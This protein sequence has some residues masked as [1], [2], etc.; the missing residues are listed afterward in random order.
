MPF[1]WVSTVHL[2]FLFFIHPFNSAPLLFCSRHVVT[3]TRAELTVCISR[4]MCGFDLNVPRSPH[5]SNQ[6]VPIFHLFSPFH[7][8]WWKI[9]FSVP[10]FFSFIADHIHLRLLPLLPLSHFSISIVTPVNNGKEFVC[11]L[12][13]D[14]NGFLFCIS[15]VRAC[16]QACVS[17]GWALLDS[18]TYYY[19]SNVSTLIRI[20]RWLY[21]WDSLASA[22]KNSFQ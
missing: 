16:V 9:Q 13:R 4:T 18:F 5:R 22:I 12:S 15:C 11:C 17:I 7:C 8:L 21:W 3:Q 14:E 1:V 2:I 19:L 20:H 6:Q 10:F